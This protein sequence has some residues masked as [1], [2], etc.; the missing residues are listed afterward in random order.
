MHETAEQGFTKLDTWGEDPHKGGVFWQ[1]G[2]FEIEMDEER[3][4][5]AE[6][7]RV[8]TPK[9][10]GQ[11]VQQ[12]QKVTGLEAETNEAIFAAL[13]TITA[14]DSQ[15]MTEKDLKDLRAG[16]AA[17]PDRINSGKAAFDEIIKRY[18]QAIPDSKQIQKE[19]RD[20]QDIMKS[21]KNPETGETLDEATRLALH[22]RLI[23]TYD[24]LSMQVTLRM[25]YGKYLDRTGFSE[26]GEKVLLKA[27]ELSDNIDQDTL[28]RQIDLM[29][30]DMQTSV[31]PKARET[32]KNW[33]LALSGEGTESGVTKLPLISRKALVQLYLG[34]QPVISDV[35]EPQDKESGKIMTIKYGFGTVFRP[36]RAFALIQE[37]A[38]K[39][40]SIMGFD[41]L[42]PNNAGR[43]VTLTSLYG[44][45]NEILKQPE[46]YNLNAVMKTNSIE[47]LQKQVK[48]SFG[49][50][51]MFIDIAAGAV[52]LLVAAR[53]GRPMALGLL[54]KAPSLAAAARPI[55]LATGLGAGASV[56]HVTFPMITGQE[57]SLTESAVH[58]AGGMGLVALGSKALGRSEIF[59]GVKSNPVSGLFWK[60]DANA[61]AQVLSKH[62]LETTGKVSEFLMKR[63]LANQ[64]KHLAALPEEMLISDAKAVEALQAANLHGRNIAGLAGELLH[65]GNKSGSR[66]PLTFLKERFSPFAIEPSAASL[67][68][69]VRARGASNFYGAL[70]GLGFY[71]STAT[72][73]DLTDTMNGET[74]KPYTFVEAV[75]EANF[76]FIPGNEPWWLK[77][78]RSTWGGTVGQ[79]LEAS[80]IMGATGLLPSLRRV[81]SLGFRGTLSQLNPIRLADRLEATSLVS[82][83]PTL[84]SLWTATRISALTAMHRNDKTAEDKVRFQRL[85]EMSQ[86]PIVD[87]DL[88]SPEQKSS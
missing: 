60:V 39:T 79:A 67:K 47:T 58:A 59:S 77:G 74:G 34:A 86:K 50:H 61:T 63:G 38:E 37:T 85:L 41:P 25:L 5:A 20:V 71:N 19:I 68:T 40:K 35:L 23:S 36:D 57:E 26:S 43:D 12:N 27:K 45:I 48:H 84:S 7:Q 31:D 64:A 78:A 75:Q 46:H 53:L 6:A 32:L 33:S 73:Y 29:D 15:Q 80:W 65:T 10:Q 28:K 2:P 56:R 70:A 14:R 24:V 83:S 69:F 11:D 13:E 62:G 55:A 8:E 30:S 81:P 16:F 54:T 18:D 22:Q 76:P 72:A 49:G 87:V 1:P 51:N 21:G 42:D 66:A 9:Q 4:K 88:T 17:S 82:N 52:G 44:G 3:K